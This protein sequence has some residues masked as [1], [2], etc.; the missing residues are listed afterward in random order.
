MNKPQA[1]KP[2]N[3]SAPKNKQKIKVVYRD[4]YFIAAHKPAGIP[5]YQEQG[6]SSSPSGFKE[7][8]EEELVER[9]FPVHRIDA[10]T[11]GL[12]LFALQS[13][14]AAFL[15]KLFKTHQIQKLYYAWVEG[16]P[17]PQG[18]I[19]TA[20]VNKHGQSESAVTYYKVLKQKAGS[21]LVEVLPKTG[22][23]HQIRKHFKSIGH[24][25]VGDPLYGN[26]IQDRLQKIQPKQQLQ[27]FAESVAFE[28][29]VTHRPI[30]IQLKLLKK[31]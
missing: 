1:P 25:I 2:P 29:P 15:I 4:S 17:P 27:L 31:I 23:F 18:A 30:K 13:K 22:R 12:V 10:D 21:S 14:F 8:L 7:H 3:H 28:H 5:T 6:R 11:E 24:P 16:T 19:K 20:L 9:L 26:T